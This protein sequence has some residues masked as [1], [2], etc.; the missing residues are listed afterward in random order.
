M[1]WVGGFPLTV[2]TDNA[3]RCR[4]AV[5]AEGRGRRLC[6]LPGRSGWPRRPPSGAH[7]ST[8]SDRRRHPVLEDRPAAP[9][10]VRQHG[11]ADL[12]LLGQRRPVQVLRHRRL[13]G[14]RPHHRQEEPRAAR[15]GRRGGEGTRRRR[16]RDP[17]HRQLERRRPRG[18]VRRPLRPGRQGRVRPAGRGP[19][20]AADGPGRDRRGRRP[21]HRLGRHPR[22]VVRPGGARARR[23]GQ[24]PYRD[25]A[26]LRAPGSAPS[27]CSARAR[28]RPTSSSA[29][30]R[31]P[32]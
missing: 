19:V 7:A 9:G 4:L 5:R 27:R 17:D 6:H 25:R 28:S 22:R 1:L 26:L 29:W 30:A 13:A 32:S 31:T 18:P 20:R 24:G 10:L 16:R 14:R 21:G 8:T 3:R 2:P 23:A 12:R 11:R 15:R